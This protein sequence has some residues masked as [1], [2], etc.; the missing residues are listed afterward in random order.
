MMKIPEDQPSFLNQVRELRLLSGRTALRMWQLAVGVVA[1]EEQAE[2][3]E[4]LAF[5]HFFIY[6][7]DRWELSCPSVS[8]DLCLRGEEVENFTDAGI[9]VMTWSGIRNLPDLS[10][11]VKQHLKPVAPWYSKPV[12]VEIPNLQPDMA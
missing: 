12:V 11:F 4:I 9:G 10:D 5:G 2:K 6:W 8:N 3:D 7:D 1:V